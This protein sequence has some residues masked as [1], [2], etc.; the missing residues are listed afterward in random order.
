MLSGM[1]GSF[2]TRTTAKML[3]HEEALGNMHPEILVPSWIP[4][5]GPEPT[6]LGQRLLQSGL[7]T[8]AQINQILREQRQTHLKFGEACLERGWITPE[9]LY[10]NI[11]SYTL[12]L[13]ELLVLRGDLAF[14]Q[15]RVALAQQRR[16][17]R[18]LG[19]ILLWRGWL[20]ASELEEILEIQQMAQSLQ[21]A[22]AWEAI[23]ELQVIRVPEPLEPEIPDT[24]P[25]PWVDPEQRQDLSPETRPLGRQ[26][27][28]PAQIAALQLQLEM[29][30]REWQAQI[31]NLEMQWTG[32]EREYQDQIA[33]LQEQLRWQQQE[34]RAQQQELIQ[35]Y[36]RRIR[37]L[38]A[39]ITQLQAEQQHTQEMLSHSQAHIDSLE[40]EIRSQQDRQDQQHPAL[41]Q[42]YQHQIQSLHSQWSQ[43]QQARQQL[44][45][46][47]TSLRAQIQR[48]TDNLNR[49]RPL[50]D[51]YRQL[52][53]QNRSLN[54]SLTQS[55]AA[56]QTLTTKLAAAQH[57][58]QIL[59]RK[60]TAP[61]STPQRRVAQSP[62]EA[63]VTIP[64][65]IPQ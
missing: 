48:H 53:D 65:S 16:Y 22:N 15:L 39:Q 63:N 47:N 51:R 37:S 6:L 45:A 62:S 49:L 2:P 8:Q 1:N 18:K 14:D 24:Q 25:G 29:Q 32:A 43:E 33:Q 35:R 56:V 58:I 10:Q 7:L 13:G 21:F 27:Q 40:E 50:A 23:H 60:L 26:P 20:Q 28:L 44:E 31:E 12:G 57:Q 30:Q 59:K 4:S 17:G 3:T 41:Y 54:Q 46:L 61:S 36:R 55:Q 11:P 42:H 38:E 19:E 34:N 5:P 52:A 9:I 64:H